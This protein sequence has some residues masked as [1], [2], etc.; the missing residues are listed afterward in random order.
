MKT[1]N[2]FDPTLATARSCAPHARLRSNASGWATSKSSTVA[3]THG[4]FMGHM[5]D[6]TIA[7]QPEGVST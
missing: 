6:S 3:T 1:T 5:W 2:R 4:R 7:R